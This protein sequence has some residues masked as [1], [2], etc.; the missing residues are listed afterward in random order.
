MLLLSS[1][2]R[3]LILGVDKACD[4]ISDKIKKKNPP[5]FKLVCYKNLKF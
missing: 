1:K 3:R 2:N 4:F 5:D